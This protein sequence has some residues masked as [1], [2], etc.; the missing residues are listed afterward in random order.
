MYFNPD[1]FKI[2]GTYIWYYFICKREVWLLSRG[3]TADQEN[4]NMAIG[5]FLHE[6]TYMRE[7]IE[8]DLF[9]M[10]LDIVK[11]EN[12][13]LVIGEIK[14]SSRY[15][16]SAK[17]QLLHYLSELKEQGIEAEGVLLIPEEK[18]REAVVLNNENKELLNQA[19][20]KILEIVVKEI[21]PKPEKNCYCKNCAYNELC[22]S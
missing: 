10:K 16:L 11:K 15:R 21:P 1:E 9:G 6:N 17:M 22:W 12:G 19:K 5:R 20:D 2:T 8:I 13:R 14:K 7:K 18:K 3:I 4:D